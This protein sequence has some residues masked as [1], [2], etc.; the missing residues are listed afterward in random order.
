MIRAK[1]GAMAIVESQTGA[2][3]GPEFKEAPY[4]FKGV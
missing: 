2:K 4:V 1:Q 3:Q